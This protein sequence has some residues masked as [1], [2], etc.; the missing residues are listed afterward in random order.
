MSI[1]NELMEAVAGAA[2]ITEL[3]RQT[4][5]LS[6]RAYKL[7]YSKPWFKAKRKRERAARQARK[8]NK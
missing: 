6:G 8:R 5:A 7:N 2:I 1:K 3:G 4:K